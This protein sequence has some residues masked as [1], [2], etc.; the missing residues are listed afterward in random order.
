MIA[1]ARLVDGPRGR[2][3][4]RRSNKS[5]S[6]CGR[7]TP[8]SPRP[9]LPCPARKSIPTPRSR[10]AWPSASC[11]G[12][13]EPGRPLPPWTTMGGAFKHAEE[14]HNREPF[15]LPQRWL[16]PR[17]SSTWKRPS[18]SSPRPT[19]S[20]AI[21]AARWSIARAQFVGIIFDGNIES[22]VW[23]SSTRTRRAA[24]L[25]VHSA[26]IEEAL[27]KL[28]DAAPLADELGK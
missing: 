2:S 1:L 27:R 3:A 17:T 20:A 6:R 5:T 28:Y 8:R 21:R 9:G 19:S 18:I 23:T 11:K 4:A 16:E 26:A 25:S 7:P 24:P 14:H 10:C 22:L 12:Y 15:N 13:D